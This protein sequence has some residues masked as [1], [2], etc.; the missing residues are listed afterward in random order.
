MSNK[1]AVRAGIGALVLLFGVST[2]AVG[3]KK[4]DPDA[5]GELYG[6]LYVIERDGNG[7]PDLRDVTYVD[8]QYRD[9]R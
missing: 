1:S 5:A 9:L 7:E 4:E 8:P 6:D 2:L 3:A